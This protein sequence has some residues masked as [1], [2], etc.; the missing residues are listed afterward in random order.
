MTSSATRV[1]SFTGTAS[2]IEKVCSMRRLGCPGAKPLLPAVG[3]A[4][5]GADSTAP[6]PDADSAR[7]ASAARVAAVGVVVVRPAAGDQ[8]HAH[9]QQDRRRPRP[10]AARSRARAC[11]TAR[12]AS[13]ARRTARGGRG[14]PCSTRPRSSSP[15]SGPWP[16]RL[17]GQRK[18]Q[19]LQLAGGLLGVAGAAGR[20]RRVHGVEVAV[21]RCGVVRMRHRRPFAA[22]SGCGAGECPRRSR[23]GRA[24]PRSRRSRARPRT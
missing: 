7:A 17:G 21:D 16:R 18:R 14:K 22:W 9:D 6:A 13:P 15:N 19:L 8:R 4:M 3:A 2:S 11:R 12:A 10:R 24:P 5:S 1:I 20:Q 23:R